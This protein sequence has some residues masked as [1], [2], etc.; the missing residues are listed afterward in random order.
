MTDKTSL[1]DRMKRNYEDVFRH[2]LPRRT[3]VIVRVDGK[4]FHTFTRSLSKP[5]SVYLHEA[6]IQGSLCVMENLQGCAFAYQQSDEVSFLLTD[7]STIKTEAPYDYNINKLVSI[8]ASAMTAGFNR[9]V[10]NENWVNKDS[11]PFSSEMGLFDSRAFAIPDPIEV[12]NYFVWRQRDCIRNSIQSLGQ[13]H[14]SHKE[15][16]GLN[17]DQVQEKLFQEKGIN[18]A[19]ENP[20]FKN[21][22]LIFPDGGVVAVEKP[23]TQTNQIQEL[24]PTRLD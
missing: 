16:H 23:F 4:A 10:C 12:Y 7:F 11:R 18:W 3:H 1:G 8:S 14:F 19:N 24:I 9:Y 17:G 6:M 13:A 15:L 21:G 5:F 2:H 22:T 20:H